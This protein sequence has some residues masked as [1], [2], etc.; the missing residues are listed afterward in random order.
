MT[1]RSNDKVNSINSCT[2]QIYWSPL[3]ILHTVTHFSSSEIK[4]I[5]VRTGQSSKTSAAPQIRHPIARR[6][7]TQININSPPI[8]HNLKNTY[9]FDRFWRQLQIAPATCGPIRALSL[10]FSSWSFPL[11]VISNTTVR[12]LHYEVISDIGHLRRCPTVISKR[13]GTPRHNLKKWQH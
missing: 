6:H 12:R 11:P 3:P 10:Q 2:N 1:H 5:R 4:H 8:Q 13:S 7:H 9:Q